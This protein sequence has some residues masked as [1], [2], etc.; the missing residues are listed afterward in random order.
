MR[1][2][3]GDYGVLSPAW[4]GSQAAAITS[5]HAFIQALLDV[6]HAWSAVLAE[7]GLIPQEHLGAITDAANA[8]DYDLAAIAAEGV[9]GGNP[10]IPL[11]GA[12][13]ANVAKTNP[14]AASSIHIG[15]TSQDIMDTAMMLIIKRAGEQTLATIKSA[16]A[17]LVSLAHEYRDTP[18]VARSLTQHSLPATFGWRVTHWLQALAQAGQNLE[19]TLT[20]TALQWGGAAGTR[21]S[22]QDFLTRTNSTVTADELVADLANKLGLQNPPPWQANRV[23]VLVQADSFAQVAAA[24]GKIANDVLISVRSEN[25]ELG[26][27]LAAGRGISSAMPHKQNPVLSVLIKNAALTAPQLLAQV[28]TG[29]VA[30]VE[31]RADGGWHTEWEALRGL[32]RTSD[33]AVEKTHEL[34]SGLRVFPDRMAQNLARHGE[35]LAT[36]R[37]VAHLAPR[38]EEHG[39]AD[40]GQGKKYLQGLI[41]RALT[42]GAS[43]AGETQL[44]PLLLAE[45]PAEAVTE[46]ELNNLLDPSAYTGDAATLVDQITSTYIDWS[47]S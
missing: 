9:G 29:A 37:M 15:A 5:D 4:A 7:A 3:H 18:M 24:C 10:L 45:L 1:V 35:L 13:R 2:L 39:V 11:L 36:E 8:D 44:K 31:E 28:Y 38:L 42:E 14:A 23:P 40:A 25:G 19:Q 16:A 12:Y 22:L 34:V 21:A 43:A 41:S 20:Q 30:N 26:E 6:E 47:H 27:P 17:A 46:S 33:A 32:V